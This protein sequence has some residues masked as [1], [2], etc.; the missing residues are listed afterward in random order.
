M[1]RYA[2]TEYDADDNPVTDDAC[3]GS[4][5]YHNVTVAVERVTWPIDSDSYVD[6]HGSTHTWPP[7]ANPPLDDPRWP[8][9]C[10]CG[11]VF[12][13][14]DKCQTNLV[15]LFRRS[16]TGDLL[17]LRDAP[18]GAM[19]NADYYPEE[20]RGSDGHTL[21]VVTP[22]GEWV[23]DGPSS[24]GTGAWKRSGVPPMVTAHPSILMPGYHGWLRD[25]TLVEC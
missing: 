20:W 17:L 8:S 25:G 15:R 23:V 2:H 13:P 11:Y 1:R 6:P 16:D 18:P 5:S 19:W 4:F 22:A 24:N 3:P 9:A 14:K 12:Q 7:P 21:V 10:E